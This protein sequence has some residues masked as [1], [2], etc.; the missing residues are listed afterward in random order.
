MARKSC[1][2]LMDKYYADDLDKP[3]LE[4][5]V[6]A[7]VVIANDENFLSVKAVEDRNGFRL[8]TPKHISNRGTRRRVAP[9][10]LDGWDNES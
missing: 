2:E 4:L 6:L 5:G 8:P 10:A 7:S 1:Y 3:L 9:G